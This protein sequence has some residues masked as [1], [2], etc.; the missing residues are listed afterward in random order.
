[1]I[2]VY[3]EIF[4]DAITPVLAF[5]ALSGESRCGFLLESVEGEEKIGRYSFIGVSPFMVFRSRPGCVETESG[6]AVERLACDNPFDALGEIMGRYRPAPM[7]GLP[8]FTGGAV[9]YISYDAVRYVENLPKPPPDDYGLPDIQLGF[10]DRIV[11]FD[12]FRN[13][14][15]AVAYARTEGAAV[16]D[17][18]A[19]ACARVDGMIA[20]LENARPEALRETPA[21]A[22]P[23]AFASTF[24]KEAYEA[25]V[26][27]TVQ[28][29]HAGDVVQ[30]VIS[31]RLEVET[32]VEPFEVYR[33]LRFVNPSPYMFC[34]CLPEA[35]LVGS[36]PEVM[37]RVEGER[38]TLRPIAG[39]IRRGKDAAEDEVLASALL[40]DPKDRAEHIMLVDLARNDVGRVSEAGTVKVSEFM[41]IEKYSHVMHIV[42]NVEGRLK[43]GE[44]AL[45]A[46]KSALP[47]GTVS[48]APK[49]RAMEIIDEL[50]PLRRGPYAGAVGYLDFFG[51][52]DTCITIRT[53]VFKNGK[54]YV[55]AGAGI[56]ADSVP[57]KEY[58]ETLNKA[59]ALLSAIRMTEE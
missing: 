40:S 5:R 32:G 3:K 53:I 24:T 30:A 18:Y 35:T 1:M 37:I 41:V 4:A 16:E 49:V 21:P 47:A 9:G 11:V 17:A 10:Y 31:Q 14:V 38:I 33:S 44:N 50:E 23:G 7:P 26:A 57:E 36:S 45:S 12:R 52:L 22:E 20:E 48:G 55:Q 56:V 6:G 58:T 51:N 43:K 29:V 39:T 54:A 15:K 46:L 34:L 42:S 28:Y 2:P 25:A 59:W 8:R 27:R 13:T 19:E